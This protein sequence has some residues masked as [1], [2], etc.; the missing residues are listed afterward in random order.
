[1][2]RGADKAFGRTQVSPLPDIFSLA[3]N[4]ATHE[5]PIAGGQLAIGGIPN[6]PHDDN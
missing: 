3:L 4:R 2:R 6:V 1:L 5:S